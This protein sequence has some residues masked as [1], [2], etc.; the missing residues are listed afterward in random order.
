[1]ESERQ[2]QLLAAISGIMTGQIPRMDGRMRKPRPQIGPTV[3][4]VGWIL[5]AGSLTELTHRGSSRLKDR[6]IMGVFYPLCFHV[7]EKRPSVL[8]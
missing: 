6:G 4:H 2:S 1:M 8:Q 7:E 3:A 5:E